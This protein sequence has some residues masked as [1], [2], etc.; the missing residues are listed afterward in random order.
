AVNEYR[1]A[2][3][4]GAG[5][6]RPYTLIKYLP[7]SLTSSSL[8]TARTPWTRLAARSAAYFSAYDGTWPVRVTAPSLTATPMWAALTLGSH[9]SSSRT[10]CCSSVSL[11]VSVLMRS[12]SVTS[13]SF[14]SGGWAG[15]FHLTGR[16]GRLPDPFCNGDAGSPP[17]RKV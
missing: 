13:G 12:S 6:R 9:F 7:G 14:F 3:A 11:I 2:A 8:A 16:V 1:S 15:R 10:S 4:D 17:G 5:N